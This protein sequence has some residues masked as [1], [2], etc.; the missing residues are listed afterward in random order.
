MSF[1]IKMENVGDVRNSYLQTVIKFSFRPMIEYFVGHADSVISLF[2]NSKLG[3]CDGIFYH[4]ANFLILTALSTFKNIPITRWR[5][6]IS[7]I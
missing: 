1:G 5:F 6:L 4:P 2:A 7:K 3:N